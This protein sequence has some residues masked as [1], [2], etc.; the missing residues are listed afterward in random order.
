MLTLYIQPEQGEG[1]R[2]SATSFTASGA[3]GERQWKRWNQV[4]QAQCELT[5]YA[6]RFAAH[7]TILDRLAGH[8]RRTR[9]LR[10][11]L[12]PW[13]Y[14]HRLERCGVAEAVRRF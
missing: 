6:I 14:R 3:K 5:G 2:P 13:I 9:Q 4:H 8:E 11:G 10:P 1:A 12:A 7:V